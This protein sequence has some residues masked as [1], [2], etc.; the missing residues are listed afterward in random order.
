MTEESRPHPFGPW[1]EIS[2]VAADS[3]VTTAA[4]EHRA[5]QLRED[6]GG[7]GRVGDDE[8]ALGRLPVDDQVVEDAAVGRAQH[9][10][11]GAADGERRRPAADRV[12]ERRARAR[13]GH[14]DLAHVAQVE[15][16]GAGPDRVVLGG[17]AAVAQRHEPAGELGHRRAEPLVHRPQRA[18]PAQSRSPCLILAGTGYGTP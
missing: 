6:H 7:V 2:P 17:L 4:P 12:V 9:R 18:C 10:V 1:M 14:R 5:V 13:P 11:P 8:E 16:R 15:Q 3:S